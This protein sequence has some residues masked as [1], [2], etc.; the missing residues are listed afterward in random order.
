ME[1]IREEL[2]G[3]SAGER[4]LTAVAPALL[5]IHSGVIAKPCP[6]N[7]KTSWDVYCL[8]FEIIAL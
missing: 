4:N 3:L 6:Y 5:D 1:I 2:R 8:Q 7:D